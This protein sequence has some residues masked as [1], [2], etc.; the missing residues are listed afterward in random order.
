MVETVTESTDGQPSSRTLEEEILFEL[1]RKVEYNLKHVKDSKHFYTQF[2][3]NFT[4]SVLLDKQFLM[5]TYSRSRD[6]PS[7]DSSSQE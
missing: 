3:F 4:H 7:D 1:S 6:S 5:R 2:L